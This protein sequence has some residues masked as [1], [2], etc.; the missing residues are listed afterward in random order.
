VAAPS[1][2][3]EPRCPAQGAL[4]QIV[5][6][7]FETFRA[8]AGSLREGEGLPRFV[9]QEFRNVLTVWL[10]RRRVRAVSLGRLRPRPAGPVF[11]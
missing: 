6:D 11:V 9:E 8:Q 1:T 7:H 5:H 10:A 3:Y 2:I 4:Y